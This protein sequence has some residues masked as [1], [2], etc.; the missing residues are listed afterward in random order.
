MDYQVLSI[1][2]LVEECAQR[3]CSE[4][5]E[6]FI[7]RTH[8]LVGSVVRRACLEWNETRQEIMDELIQDVYVKLWADDCAMLKHFKPLH[9]NA[10]L[11]YLKVVTANLVYDYFRKIK[12]LEDKTEPI[13]DAFA[14]RQNHKHSKSLENEIF[15]NKVDKILRQRGSGPQEEKERAIFWLYYRQG[16]TAKEIA[17]IPGIKLGV[18]GVESCIFRLIV[19]IR[20]KLFGDRPG[21]DPGGIPP[22]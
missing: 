18:K 22:V 12:H 10:F 13:D 14:Q 16:M 15:F 2:Q 4:A 21:G 20:K 11:G 3:P 19:C 6:E 9:E 17:S 5:S 8:R 7:L 1:E